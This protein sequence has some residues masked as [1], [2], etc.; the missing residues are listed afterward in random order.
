VLAN[1]EDQNMSF[2]VTELRGAAGIRGIELRLFEARNVAQVDTAL[3]QIAGWRAQAVLPLVNPMRYS[4]RLIQWAAQR[5]VPVMYGYNTDAVAGGLMAYDADLSDHYQHVAVY[6]AKLLA[7]AVPATLPVERPT[8]FELTLNIKT[9][10][11][12]G[13]KFPQS[14]LSRADQVIE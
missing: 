14:L 11:K 6:V 13:L 4:E 12:L 3:E 8:R 5:R 10:K 9:A 2:Q 7:G 1:P